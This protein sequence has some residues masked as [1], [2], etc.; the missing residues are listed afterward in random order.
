MQMPWLAL[1]TM[2]H[3]VV[4][5]LYIREAGFK[6]CV[7]V[8][9]RSIE[10]AKSIIQPSVFLPEDLFEVSPNQTTCSSTILVKV[11]RAARFFSPQNRAKCNLHT[12]CRQTFSSPVTTTTT[13]N[14]RHTEDRRTTIADSASRKPRRPLS[15]SVRPTSRPG[16]PV[17][18]LDAKPS[19]CL[20]FDLSHFATPPLDWPGSCI[21][22]SIHRLASLTCL[23]NLRSLIYA[24]FGMLALSRAVAH[25]AHL[26]LVADS[27]SYTQK[28]KYRCPGCRTQ[29]CSLPC[30]KRHQQRASCNGKRDPTV[31]VKRSQLA[32]P[33]GIDQD[34]NYLKSVERSI[35][36]AARETSD[37]GVGVKTNSKGSER[38][39]HPESL[40]NRY[41][42]SNRI[43][44]ER[45]PKGMSR[46]KTNQTRFTKYVC[47]LSDLLHYVL[48]ALQTP[49]CL[50]DG[51]VDWR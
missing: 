1:M 22:L 13:G 39:L 31:F 48:R 14:V 3:N 46:Q 17:W 44:I 8:R 35:D 30:Y 45:A 40:L 26:S 47:R 12:R 34:Y 28:P 7:C 9:D 49:K 37:R 10:T 5:R 2:K 23:T 43:N 18:L 29:T 20:L 27:S 21:R 4:T 6:G 25:S 24:V 50:V 51:R 15:D 33:A 38:A 36:H 16:Q 19:A 42:I 11:A 41:L 32:T